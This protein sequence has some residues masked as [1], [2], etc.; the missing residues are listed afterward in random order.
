M[1]Q[2]SQDF[3]KAFELVIIHEAGFVNDPRDPGGKTKFG[4]SDRRDGKVDGLADLDGDGSGVKAIE[5]LTLEDA[6]NIY[7]REYWDKCCCDDL[8]SA[9]ATALFDTAVNVGNHQAKLLLQRALGVNDDGIIGPITMKK[10]Q[11]ASQPYLIARFMAER[12]MY[13]AALKSWN[14]YGL[15]WT[16]RVIET[17]HYC[18]SLTN[19]EVT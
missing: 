11:Q 19:K 12:Q 14:T 4:I 3:K 10:A 5:L 1:S 16:R 15:G 2:L 13:Y 8:P 6:G 18:L 9:I 7:K 17:A